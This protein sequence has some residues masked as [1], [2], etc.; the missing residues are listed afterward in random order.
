MTPLAPIESSTTRQLLIGS[1]SAARR[2]KNAGLVRSTEDR[3]HCNPTTFTKWNRQSTSSSSVFD[4]N[5]AW[6]PIDET[7]FLKY[8]NLLTKEHRSLLVRL[9]RRRAA[10]REEVELPREQRR[11]AVWEP[12]CNSRKRE[13]FSSFFLLKKQEMVTKWLQKHSWTWNFHIH[14]I[15]KKQ[16]MWYL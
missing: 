8:I 16:H 15:H 6:T 3:L 4:L 1:C 5:Q 2:Q 9:L 12:G 10:R 14:L 7:G 13:G 11:S